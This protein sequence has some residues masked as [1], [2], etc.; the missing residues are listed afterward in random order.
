VADSL[1][2][3][4]YINDGV[5]ANMAPQAVG[6]AGGSQPHENRQPFLAVNFILSLFGIFP[7][8]T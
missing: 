8:P 2:V 7:S 4:V 6:V 1:S 5:D 3:S